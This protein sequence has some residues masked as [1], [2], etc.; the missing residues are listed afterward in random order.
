MDI[1]RKQWLGIKKS[2]SGFEERDYT[3]RYLPCM[4]LTN[5]SLIPDQGRGYFWT[6]SQE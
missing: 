3:I 6:K 2:S 5:P 4:Q 1:Y